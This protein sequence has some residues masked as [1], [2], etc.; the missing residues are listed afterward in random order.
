MGGR[1]ARKIYHI[2]GG[3]TLSSCLVMVCEVV[4]M[5]VGL[6][7]LIIRRGKRAKCQSRFSVSAKC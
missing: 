2:D 5:S 3:P 7:M 4:K 1:I 6:R